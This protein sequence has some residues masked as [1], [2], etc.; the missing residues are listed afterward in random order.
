MAPLHVVF[1]NVASTFIF[2]NPSGGAIHLIDITLP[3]FRS[4]GPWAGLPHLSRSA[5]NLFMLQLGW[6]GWFGPMGQ[7]WFNRK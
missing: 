7:I 3:G 4:L 1:A 5:K 6:A 2:V